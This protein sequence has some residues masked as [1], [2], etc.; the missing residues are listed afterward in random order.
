ML[1]VSAESRRPVPSLVLQLSGLAVSP[2]SLRDDVCSAAHPLRA[3]PPA[4]DPEQSAVG[5][6][7]PSSAPN[8]QGFGLISDSVGDGTARCR[9][10]RGDDLRSV[11][12]LIPHCQGYACQ[13]PFAQKSLIVGQ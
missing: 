4:S 7:V 11:G 1:M 10:E 8:H 3:E 12:R 5:T 2:R 13:C 6:A 9:G